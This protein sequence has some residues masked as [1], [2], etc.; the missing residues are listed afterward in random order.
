MERGTL[1]ALVLGLSALS[2]GNLCGVFHFLP[3]GTVDE[4]LSGC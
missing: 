1:R 2:I 4:A 3:E